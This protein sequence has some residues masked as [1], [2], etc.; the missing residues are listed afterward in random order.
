LKDEVLAAAR[1]LPPGFSKGDVTK[2]T[3][4]KI[5]I[6]RALT[7]LVAEGNLKKGDRRLARYWIN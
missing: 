4:T 3:R 2:K 5:N 6:G 7:L 1:Q